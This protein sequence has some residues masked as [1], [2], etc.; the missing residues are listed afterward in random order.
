MDKVI[1]FDP[2]TNSFREVSLEIAK[3]FVEATKK[4]EEQLKKI[5]ANKNEQK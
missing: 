3:K 2:F 1:I 4:V 5:E